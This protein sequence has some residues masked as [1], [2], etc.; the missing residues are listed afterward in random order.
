MDDADGGRR[1]SRA[2]QGASWVN[3]E[4][5]LVEVEAY[6]D[7]DAVMDSRQR[8]EVGIGLL[9]HTH[10]LLRQVQVG[11]E[12][13][14][15]RLANHLEPAD[16]ALSVRRGVERIRGWDPTPAE[17]RLVAVAEELAELVG[18]GGAVACLL[19]P[20]LALVH[21]QVRDSRPRGHLPIPPRF[22]RRSCSISIDNT[23]QIPGQHPV[24]DRPHGRAVSGWPVG[25]GTARDLIPAGGI[26]AGGSE[27]ALAGGGRRRVTV[28]D[29]QRHR[30]VDVRQTL[31]AAGGS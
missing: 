6:V 18:R 16:V 23:G 4:G 27:G 25:N 19:A 20:G 2:R 17:R 8:L 22:R 30:P 11:R 14:R 3:L 15:P 9:A 31:A 5:R 29:P 10:N 12:G 1:G 26:P 7:H 24:S 21:A 13:R 28:A